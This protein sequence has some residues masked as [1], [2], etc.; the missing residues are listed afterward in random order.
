MD[1]GIE[2]DLFCER[3]V[4]GEMNLVVSED[5]NAHHEFVFPDLTQVAAAFSLT[6]IERNQVD[7]YGFLFFLPL[8]SQ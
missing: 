8:L 6:L 5:G 7:G 2:W 4:V 3:L 1:N